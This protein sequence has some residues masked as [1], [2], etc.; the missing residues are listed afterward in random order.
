MNIAINSMKASPV[1]QSVQSMTYFRQTYGVAKSITMFHRLRT[2]YNHKAKAATKDRDT[3][4]FK[5]YTLLAN[6]FTAY[7]KAA[8]HVWT[9]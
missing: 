4:A 7:I 2:W 5:K 1:T 8:R 6:I 9:V 3:A